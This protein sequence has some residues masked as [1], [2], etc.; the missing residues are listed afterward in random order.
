MPTVKLYPQGVSWSTPAL[1]HGGGGVRGKAQGW[2]RAAVR[3][4]RLKLMSVQPWALG[5]E[6]ELTV[7]AGADVWIGPDGQQALFNP[8]V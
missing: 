8:L 6:A 7:P 4:N 2:T 5:G 3:R 1:A